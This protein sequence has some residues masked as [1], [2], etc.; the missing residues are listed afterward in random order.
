MSA[1]GQY[2]GSGTYKSSFSGLFFGGEYSCFAMLFLD[3]FDEVN[4]KYCNIRKWFYS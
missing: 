4:D 1:S 2:R 3:I